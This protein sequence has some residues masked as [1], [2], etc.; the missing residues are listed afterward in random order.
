MQLYINVF[1]ILYRI[2]HDSMHV[3]LRSSLF[4]L[5]FSVVAHSDDLTRTRLPLAHTR[6]HT[7]THMYTHIDTRMH[8]QEMDRGLNGLSNLP[9]KNS[10]KI[11]TRAIEFCTVTVAT[12]RQIMGA[13][14][15]VAAFVSR[16]MNTSTHL[17]APY[18][19]VRNSRQ[20]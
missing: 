1:Y 19:A 10:A 3:H 16:A 17:Q 2:L 9:A 12:Q 18:L 15:E 13:Q 6:T 5:K 8:V 20:R 7:Y 14:M 4:M 11:R